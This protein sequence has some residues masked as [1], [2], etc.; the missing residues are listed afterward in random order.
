MKRY[1]FFPDATPITWSITTPIVN[2]NPDSSRTVN[3][4]PTSNA[5]T[6]LWEQIEPDPNVT[7]ATITPNNTTKNIVVTMP[8]GVNTVRYR[9]TLN[10]NTSNYK[11]VDILDYKWKCVDGVC[12]Q[13]DT[14]IY[15]TQAECEAALIP[16]NFI[17][18][19]CVGT[20]YT[21]NW[22]HYGNY[23]GSINGLNSFNTVTG[24]IEAVYQEWRIVGTDAVS[25]TVIVTPTET[26]RIAAFATIPG[27]EGGWAISFNVTSI[28]GTPDNCGN[29]YICP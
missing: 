14:G 28:T 23:S 16:A 25:E 5:I 10:G 29:K 20:I 24:P 9:V 22:S 2:H 17:G 13:D 4:N 26:V 11:Y 15:N 1:L 3:L 7:Y 21:V 8:V 12:I 19:Q 18:G 6:Y 27:Y